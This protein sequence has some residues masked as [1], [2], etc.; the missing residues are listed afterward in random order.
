[1]PRLLRSFVHDTSGATAVEY[2]LTVALIALVITGSVAMLGWAVRDLFT[3]V[4]SS[5][6]LNP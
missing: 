1:M 2:S 4:A 3:D 5:D 6:A